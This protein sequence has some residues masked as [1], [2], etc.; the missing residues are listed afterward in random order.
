MA[1]AKKGDK[2]RIN[3]TGTLEDGTVFDSTLEDQE[4]ETEECESEDCG[5]GCGEETGP[6]EL[7]IGGGEF[8]TQIEEALVGMAPGE[9]KSVTIPAKDAFGEYD[10][11]KVF[12]VPRSDMPEDL[13]PE[14]GDELTISNEDDEEFEVTVVEVQEDSVTFD[15][16]HPLAGE[17]L[18]FEIELLE[19]I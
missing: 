15:T 9:K 16:N 2:V 8:F 19:I 7:T 14:V 13:K 6:M 5:C 10:T 4:C 11:E 12:N 3:Y 18:T 17:D 1:Q